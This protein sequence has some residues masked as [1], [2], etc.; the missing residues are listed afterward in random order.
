[1]V[2]PKKAMNGLNKSNDSG[3]KR[4]LFKLQCISP[5]TLSSLRFNRSSEHE[6]LSIHVRHKIAKIFSCGRIWLQKLC[7]QHKILGALTDLTMNP[8]SAVAQT[9]TLTCSSRNVQS[10]GSKGKSSMPAHRDG[11]RNTFTFPSLPT[12]LCPKVNNVQ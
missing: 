6:F 1:M 4:G 2:L 11:A 8:I 9:H 7:N 12:W 5:R 10:C 3:S